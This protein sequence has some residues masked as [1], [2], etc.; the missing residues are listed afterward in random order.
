MLQ[1]LSQD[2]PAANVMSAI[3]IVLAKGEI[4]TPDLGGSSTTREMSDAILEVLRHP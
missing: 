4:R 3:E 2:V 1:S